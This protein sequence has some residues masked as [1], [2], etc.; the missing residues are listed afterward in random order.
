MTAI[1]S[2]T[3]LLFVTVIWVCDCRE[4]E[5]P[6][7]E[8]DINARYVFCF[9]SYFC[10]LLQTLFT[11]LLCLNSAIRGW[12][13]DREAVISGSEYCS[14]STNPFHLSACGQSRSH[15]SEKG[16]WNTNSTHCLPI[17]AVAANFLICLIF[18]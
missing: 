3:S 18:Y 1:S 14:C 4:V 15:S 12:H 8:L 2:L 13:H 10:E 17:L 7:L 9:V 5:H 16:L 11:R 6:P